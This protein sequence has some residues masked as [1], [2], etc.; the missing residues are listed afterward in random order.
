[1]KTRI[2]LAENS[3]IERLQKLDKWPDSQKWQQMIFCEEVIVLE[4]DENL[5]GLLHY[6]VLWTTVPFI[7]LIY[8]K[9]EFQKHGFS[10]Q[11]LEFLKKHLK[12]KGYVAL[13]SSSQTNE[14]VPQAW[15][16]HMGFSTNG[17]IENIDDDN[18]GELVYRMLL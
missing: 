15:H 18:I 14:P 12:K 16:V 17:I 1:M 3:D 13:L 8:I 10:R 2:R 5:A 7:G 6:S 9:P 4:I 11:M